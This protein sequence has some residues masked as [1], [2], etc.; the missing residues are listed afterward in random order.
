[1]VAAC[2]SSGCGKLL[3]KHPKASRQGDFLPILPP[4]GIPR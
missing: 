3:I 2:R 1:M 4:I